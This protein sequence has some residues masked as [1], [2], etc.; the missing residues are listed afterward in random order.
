MKKQ[1]K[2]L[3][4]FIKAINDDEGIV[5]AF[6]AVMGNVDHQKDVI[7]PG[8]FTKTI[9]ERASQIRV[10]DNHNAR[11]CKDVLGVPLHF[12]EVGRNRLPSK[13]LQ[14]YP[15]ATGGLLA[16]IQ[17][18]LD[19]P[20]GKGVFDRIK[21]GAID[22]YSIGYDALDVTRD[23][24][25]TAD[26]DMVIRR[27]KTIRLWE[28]SPVIFAANEATTTVGAKGDDEENPGEPGA[29]QDDQ[30]VG[31]A[32][33]QDDQGKAK[34][35]DEEDEDP[36]DEKEPGEGKPY[37][38][39]FQ[40]GDEH[41]VYKI[42]DDGKQTGDTLGCHPTG[43]EAI[44]QIAAL[45]IADKEKADNDEEEDDEEKGDS[46]GGQDSALVKE[47]V[48]LFEL[49]AQEKAQRE[50]DLPQLHKDIAGTKEMTDFGPVQRLGDVLQ[51]NVHKSFTKLAD[52][53][54][55][56]GLL[57]REERIALSA[58]IG[59]ALDILTLGIPEEVSQR[60][61]W[62]WDYM[63]A[64]VVSE[65]KSGRDIGAESEDRLIDAFT[66]ML[67]AGR[68]LARRNETRLVAALAT[69]L[70]VFE[71]AGIDVPGF[72]K[73]P[74]EDDE[75]KTN[76]AADGTSP[77]QAP[78]NQAAKNS[79]AGPDESTLEHQKLLALIEL[80]QAA[81]EIDMED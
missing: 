39:V 24:V 66:T 1:F 26:G 46:E 32:A 67:K 21:N 81:I 38:G 22:A 34:E 73:E 50:A 5:D 19:T 40:D 47:V 78:E 74:E 69:L 35:S 58:Q 17:F 10:L 68:V 4:I 31:D 7:D 3:P 16:S 2:K 71:D 61:V 57:S 37:Y 29:D 20:E 72:S 13:M 65:I 25:K 12:E 70:E 8:A 28:I 64:E 6:V 77:D 54:Y 41:C 18:L 80:E 53:W 27:L 76:D 49:F 36:K 15:D 51:G 44:A 23:T 45:N 9:K 59:K 33:D 43:K 63:S 14:E 79:E 52:K 48:K 56:E 62:E 55:C 42:A 30:D 75:D 60:Q 11:S